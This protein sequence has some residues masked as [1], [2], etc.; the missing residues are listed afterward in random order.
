MKTECIAK[1]HVGRKRKSNEDSI[2]ANNAQNIFIIADGM[3]GL[4]GGREA[5][6]LAVETVMNYLTD[7]NEIEDPIRMLSDSLEEANSALYAYSKQSLGNRKV[8]TTLTALMIK[9]SKYYIG[10]IG[11]SRCYRLR[12]SDMK[13]ITEDQTLVNDLLKQGRI[14]AE[15]AII[16]PERHIIT[17]AVGISESISALFYQGEIRPK[18]I[19]LLCTDG[20]Y[21]LVNEDEIKKEMETAR[22]D[23]TRAADNLIS[24][25]NRMGGDDNISLILVKISEE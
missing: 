24:T 15:Q 4:A 1:S 19:Y 22:S 20:L 12:L 6:R 21:D 13:T 11:D 16:H 18:D 3:G 10:H 23:L 5:S 17:E 9:E 7:K 2:L 8:G 25:A 14:T